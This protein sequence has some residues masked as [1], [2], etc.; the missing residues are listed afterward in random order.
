MS[1]L[2][3]TRRPGG[4]RRGYRMGT[5]DDPLRVSL[6]DRRQDEF[7]TPKLLKLRVLN[8]VALGSFGL[9]DLNV[10]AFGLLDPVLVD[11]LTFMTGVPGLQ[12]FSLLS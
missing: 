9:T 5:M 4:D 8:N 3:R 1:S 12:Y 10:K 6:R 7:E 11:M 2:A